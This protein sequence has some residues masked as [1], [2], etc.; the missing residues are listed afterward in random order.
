MLSQLLA[1]ISSERLGECLISSGIEAATLH[2]YGLS[3]LE[4]QSPGTT[5]MALT[6][7]L[8]DLAFKIPVELV[9]ANAPPYKLF[10]YRFDRCNHWA[11]SPWVGT[12]HHTIDLLY[13]AGIPEQYPTDD[14]ETDKS[15]SN[16]VMDAVLTF[17]NGMPSWIQ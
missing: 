10:S 2:A 16:K 5:L 8:G 9:K 13:L 17:G 6:E 4:S 1:S 3:N 12:A 14:P 7:F 11:G 15:L